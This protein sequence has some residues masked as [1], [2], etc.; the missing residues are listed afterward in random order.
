MESIQGSIRIQEFRATVISD[1][2][3]AA[4][5]SDVSRMN[6]TLKKFVPLDFNEQFTYLPRKIKPTKNGPDTHNPHECIAFAAH[7]NIMRSH[8]CTYQRGNKRDLFRAIFFDIL[9]V[10]TCAATMCM[11]ELRKLVV[12]TLLCP[13]YDMDCSNWRIYHMLS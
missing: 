13:H 7:F 9:S 11:R 5:D 3:W 1:T 2:F 6:S 10:R 8:K 4:S 12:D